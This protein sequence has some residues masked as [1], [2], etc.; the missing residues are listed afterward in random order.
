MD[1]TEKISLQLKIL[2]IVKI[3]SGLVPNVTKHLH[4][5]RK[6]QIMLF[7]VKK[8]NADYVTKALH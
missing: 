2:L 1:F 5:M 8:L 6:Y 4:L 7:L 3:Q